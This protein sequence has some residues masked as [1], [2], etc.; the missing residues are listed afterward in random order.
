[1][2]SM[3]YYAAMK[4]NFTGFDSDWEVHPTLLF[5]LTTTKNLE[6]LWNDYQSTLKN[7]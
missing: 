5:P 3:K 1:M 7:E 6:T 4:N 2:W